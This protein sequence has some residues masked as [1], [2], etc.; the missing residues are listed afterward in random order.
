MGRSWRIEYEGG[1]YHILSRGNERKEIY[2]DD[3]DRLSFLDAIGNARRIPKSMNEDR[4][5]LICLVWQKCLLT[6]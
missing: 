2:Y 6:N 3:Q 1:F 5:L 4:D